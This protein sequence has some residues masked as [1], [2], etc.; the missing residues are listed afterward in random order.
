MQ[1]KQIV[2]L[3]IIV[4]LLIIFFQ[5]LITAPIQILLWTVNVS[6]SLIILVPFL[7]GIIVGFL[8]KSSLA[9]RKQK[10]DN[11]DL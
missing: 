6:K 2:I 4:L 11:P 8:I 3:I 9:K 10:P 7:L 5:N 1:P